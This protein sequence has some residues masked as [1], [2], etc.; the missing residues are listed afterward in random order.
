MRSVNSDRVT[1]SEEFDGSLWPQGYF[2]HHSCVCAA[3]AAVRHASAAEGFSSR[4][5]QR[6][7]LLALEWH[8]DKAWSAGRYRLRSFLPPHHARRTLRGPLFPIRTGDWILANAQ[9]RR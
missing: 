2:Y 4:L 8:V 1:A 7:D 3:R 9:I 5:G 6:S